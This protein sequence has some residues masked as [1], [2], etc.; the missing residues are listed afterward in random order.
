MAA[1]QDVLF[2]HRPSCSVASSQDQNASLVVNRWINNV[3]SLESTSLFR[4]FGVFESSLCMRYEQWR[5]G[6]ALAIKES[7]CEVN[8]PTA[9]SGRRPLIALWT[10]NEQ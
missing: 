5:N 9:D 6:E 4:L 10:N 2:S 8:G 7:S 3:L 1:K